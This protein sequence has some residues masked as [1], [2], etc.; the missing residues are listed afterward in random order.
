[1]FLEAGNRVGQE[2]SPPL[3]PLLYRAIQVPNARAKTLFTTP[4]T[5]VPGQPNKVILPEL[6]IFHKPAGTAFTG[7]SAIQLTA[8]A[9]I[10]AF[11]SVAN[12]LD[13]TTKRSAMASRFPLGAQLISAS[14]GLDLTLSVTA[15]NLA[16]SNDTDLFVSFIYRVW[17]DNPSPWL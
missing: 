6:T 11:V 8:G 14:I 2:D 4:L 9:I 15:S 13:Q 16:T 3:P 12:F 1:M 17:E 10:L 7:G 5:V